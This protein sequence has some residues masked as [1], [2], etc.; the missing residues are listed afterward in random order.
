MTAPPSATRPEKTFSSSAIALIAS[1]SLPLLGVLFFDWD[2]AAIVV[3]Y[4]S[5][6][7]IIGAYNIAKM[8]QVAGLGGVGTSL[9]FLIHYGGFCAVHGLFIQS[10]LLETPELLAD[11]SWPFFLVFVELLVDVCAQMFAIAPASWIIAF[12]G[13]A[14]S[15]GYSFLT[16]FLQRGEYR[17]TTVQSLMAAPYK[18]IMVMHVAIIAGGFGIHALGEPTVLLLV[19][20][21][22][23]TAVDVTLHRRS[24]RGSSGS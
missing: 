23:K 1:N 20:V 4:W 3:L 19:L 10:L 18:R 12:V 24:H 15:H 11:Q 6:N 7:L 16:N 17:L 13:L 22:L 21:G 8:I 5:E 2:V 9:F 14:I